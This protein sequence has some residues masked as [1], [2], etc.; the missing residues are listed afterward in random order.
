VTY[1]QLALL[2]ACV[3]VVVDLVVLRTRLLTR[4]AFWV[5]YGVIVFFQLITNGVLTGWS[6]VRYA[7]DDIV[8]SDRVMFLGDGRI[9]FAPVEDLLFG[10][11]LV[12]LT[13][14]L[15]VWWGSRGVQYRPL[16]GP[17]RWRKDESADQ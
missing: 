3:I 4:R 17:P 11:T 6:I 15:W 12:V 8:G 9:A 1:T 7:G 10:F 16:A 14:S 5:S 2:G 13:L